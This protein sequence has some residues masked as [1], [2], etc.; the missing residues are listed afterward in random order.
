MNQRNDE[1]PTEDLSRLPHS[2]ERERLRKH[3]PG[4][5]DPIER[6]LGHAGTAPSSSRRGPGSSRASI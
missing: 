3:C 2:T 5:E 6:P 4:P 1:L